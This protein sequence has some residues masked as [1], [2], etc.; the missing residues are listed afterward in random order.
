MHYL[1][2]DVVKQM[3]AQIVRDL[4]AKMAIE[5]SEKAK[6]VVVNF[7]EFGDHVILH[8]V[9]S[10]PF[11]QVETMRDLLRHLALAFP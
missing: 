1:I 2:Q 7:F 9:K 3:G 8:L 6:L 4:V 10:F 11:D 5:D